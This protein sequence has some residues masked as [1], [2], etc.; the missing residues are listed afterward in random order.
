M[1]IALTPGGRLVQYFGADRFVLRFRRRIELRF[2]GE[3]VPA[4]SFH[5]D[6]RDNHAP[7]GKE[8]PSRV[9]EK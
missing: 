6:D 8:E 7:G 2:G 5:G 3:Q 9:R 1:A 4:E